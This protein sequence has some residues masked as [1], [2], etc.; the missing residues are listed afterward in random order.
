MRSLVT[1]VS[2]TT[3][4]AAAKLGRLVPS[5]FVRRQH[6]RW[7]TRV[8]NWSPVQFSSYAQRTKLNLSISY[9]CASRVVAPQRNARG[10]GTG[11]TNVAPTCLIE[12]DAAAAAAATDK[13]LIGRE[14]RAAAVTS[15]VLHQAK[16]NYWN[17]V[18]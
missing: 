16:L 8:R 17:E 15:R 11:N 2:A 7:N 18:I 5:Q 10:I 1:R 9:R 14:A 4:L 6:S 12:E 13:L 3:W